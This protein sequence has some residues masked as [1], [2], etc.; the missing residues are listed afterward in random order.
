[1]KCKED[2]IECMAKGT[3]RAKINTLLS[4]SITL[5]LIEQRKRLVQNNIIFE[6]C[7]AGGL[8]AT[9]KTTVEI[10]YYTIERR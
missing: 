7:V 1:V 5:D 4:H 2:I 6:R 10:T 3:Y 8:I 9:T